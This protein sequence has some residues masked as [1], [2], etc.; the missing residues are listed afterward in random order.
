MA[1]REPD[2]AQRDVELVDA[3][4]AGGRSAADVSRDLVQVSGKKRRQEG[5]RAEIGSRALRVEGL[6]ELGRPRDSM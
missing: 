5:H 4:P 3:E 1:R 6:R 2:I